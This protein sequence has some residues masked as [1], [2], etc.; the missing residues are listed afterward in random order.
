MRAALVVVVGT[1]LA[2]AAAA[3]AAQAGVLTKVD[4]KYVYT[5][6]DLRGGQHRHRLRAS[7]R[8]QRR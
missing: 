4:N 6:G 8:G 1:I 2:I 5:S 7:R 3:P